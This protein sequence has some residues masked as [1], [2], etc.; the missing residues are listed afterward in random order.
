MILRGRECSNQV[1]F[2]KGGLLELTDRACQET[3]HHQIYS[4]SLKH[5]LSLGG[6]RNPMNPAAEV[7]EIRRR[8]PANSAQSIDPQRP[9]IMIKY[10][11]H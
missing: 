7:A 11:N 4:C 1:N 5:H 9:E 8:G 6:N 3:S 2:V 10:L